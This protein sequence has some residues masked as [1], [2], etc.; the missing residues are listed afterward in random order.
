MSKPKLMSTSQ[1]ASSN[2]LSKKPCLGRRWHCS[3]VF[4]L[5]RHGSQKFVVSWFVK[6][7]TNQY[8]SGVE[9]YTTK[10][11][12]QTQKPG[13]LT[14]ETQTLKPCDDEVCRH[15]LCPLF[16]AIAPTKSRTTIFSIKERYCALEVLFQ[17]SYRKHF[18]ENYS[19]K[20]NNSV[21]L[22]IASEEFPNRAQ[23]VSLSETMSLK[24][25]LYKNNVSIKETFYARLLFIFLFCKELQC[26][27]LENKKNKDLFTLRNFVSFPTKPQFSES[28]WQS[29][30]G[31]SIRLRPRPHRK[32]IFSIIGTF[33]AVGFL[34]LQWLQTTM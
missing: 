32:T 9:H 20:T 34:D 10:S 15:N 23:Y 17:H 12:P 14:P 27:E 6:F 18:F 26:C 1:C 3:V 21:T 29:N 24:N 25:F 30:V 11:R 4:T 22:P 33:R 2:E 13:N 5:D 31:W 28:A 16:S 19:N 7:Q 8:N